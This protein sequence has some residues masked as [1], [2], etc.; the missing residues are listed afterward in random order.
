[1]N[2]L[3]PKTLGVPKTEEQLDEIKRKRAQGKVI[4][5]P[6]A[7]DAPGM[8]HH[9]VL[10]FGHSLN[11]ETSKLA[12]VA[13]EVL[14]GI[15]KTDLAI[16]DMFDILRTTDDSKVGRASPSTMCETPSCR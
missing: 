5:E 12:D 16:S 11:L 13:A 10:D 15:T 3:P 2:A 1:M 6:K 8:A 4:Y 9:D 14:G 7:F